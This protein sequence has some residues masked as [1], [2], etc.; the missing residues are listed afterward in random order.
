MRLS[1]TRDPPL[2][3]IPFKLLT[4]VLKKLDRMKPADK[5]K[6][7]KQ[8][9]KSYADFSQSSKGYSKMKYLESK[10]D[11]IEESILKIWGERCKT[12]RG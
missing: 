11:S 12:S 5:L 9:E 1:L 2:Q 4:L 8:A 3:K 6:F 7:Q 10:T